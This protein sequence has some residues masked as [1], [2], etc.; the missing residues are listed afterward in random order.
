M[1]KKRRNSR[2]ISLDPRVEAVARYKNDPL[3]FVLWNWPWGKKGTELE[4]ETGPEPWQADVLTS[5]GEKCRANAFNGHA[6]VPPIR[7][8]TSSGHGI[9]K[10]ALVCWIIHWIMSTRPYCNVTVTASTLP[11]LKDKTWKELHKWHRLA[12]NGDWFVYSSARGNMSF[13]AK[14]YE[15][16]WFAVAQTC[17]EDNS[18]AFQ[19]QHQPNSTSAYILDEASAVPDKIWEAAEGGLTDG[20][21]MLIAFGNPTRNTGAFAD[22]FGK[23]KH[24]WT[25]RQI[26]AR[27]VSRGNK[28]LFNEWIED[29][30]EDSDFVRIRVKGVFPRAGATQF[31][32][33]DVVQR[34]IGNVLPVSAY[35][36][37]P[38]ILGVDVARLG[39]D[40]SVVVR[41]Q[42]L[43]CSGLRDF[44]G[45][46]MMLVDIVIAEIEEFDPDAVFIDAVGVGGP[47]VDR[48]RQL[49]HNVIPVSGAEK[50]AQRMYFNKR[51]EM[52]GA[53][54]EWLQT[55]GSIPKHEALERQLIQQ[56]YGLSERELIQLVGKKEM[57]NMGCESP[58]YADALS[59]T[60]AYP[61]SIDDAVEAFKRVVRD[62]REWDAVPLMQHLWDPIRSKN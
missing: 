6:P 7:E 18:E 16:E 11:Q 37:A 60:F 47:V 29:Y 3:S 20:E 34:A 10:S 23:Y 51:A 46:T 19:G 36:W 52:W 17:K 27:N 35:A 54:R 39:G 53:M 62:N 61:V 5:L 28:Q 55:G 24:R 13:R 32:P 56:E 40:M 30:G 4:H 41:R 42:G 21:P 38:K 44:A 1:G 9:G 14:G 48:L 58:D 26:D 15:D 12:F 50:S 57:K 49:G 8:A 59:F 31:I 45:N 33:T 22:C 25:T 2:A 43:M